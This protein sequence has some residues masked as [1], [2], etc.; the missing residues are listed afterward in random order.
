MPDVKGAAE[1][2]REAHKPGEPLLLPNVW[3]VAS[4]KMV[5]EL[6]FSAV[7]TSSSAVAHSFGQPDTD[8]MP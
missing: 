3:D 4:A 5:E 1:A 6:G 8:S 2:L 7:A